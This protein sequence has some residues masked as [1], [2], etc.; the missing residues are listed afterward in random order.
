MSQ[1]E[2]A[3]D[4]SQWGTLSNNFAKS[5]YMLGT[6]DISHF[7]ILHLGWLRPHSH[8]VMAVRCQYTLG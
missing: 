6:S 3:A 7:L 4:V 2:D 8:C 1:E 5:W